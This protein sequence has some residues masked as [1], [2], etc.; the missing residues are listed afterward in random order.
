MYFQTGN[1]EINKKY[2]ALTVAIALFAVVLSDVCIVQ[3][4]HKTIKSTGMCY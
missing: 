2:N 3:E 1:H 4:C